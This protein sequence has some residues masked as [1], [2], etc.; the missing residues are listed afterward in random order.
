VISAGSPSSKTASSQC[1]LSS[2]DLRSDVAALRARFT[3]GKKDDKFFPALDKVN[4]VARAIVD[5]HLRD[6][7]ANGLHVTWISDL[8][9]ID[10]NLGAHPCLAVVQAPKPACKDLRLPDLGH[11]G[12]IR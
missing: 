2:S 7:A 4:P 1:A 10:P 6:S 3:A 5:P 11:T 12:S 8:R 9:T